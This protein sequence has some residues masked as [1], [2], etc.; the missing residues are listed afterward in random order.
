VDVA[1]RIAALE[2]ENERLRERVTQLEGLGD[3]AILAPV[4]WRL[5]PAEA[6]L[7]NGLM[8]RQ[9][10]SKGALM[11]AI[12]QGRDEAE[13]KI[14]D[15]FVCKIRKKLKPFGIAIETVWGQGYRIP[16][17]VKAQVRAIYGGLAA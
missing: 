4:D 16:P 3:G 14:V 13:I 8:S 2:A 6:R 15:V 1:A 11:D 10:A 12:Y 7:F 17:E 9:M 5:T